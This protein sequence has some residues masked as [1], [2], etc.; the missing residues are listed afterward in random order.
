MYGAPRH[1]VHGLWRNAASWMTKLALQHAMGA[2]AATRVSA[3]RAFRR[4]LCDAFATYNGPYVSIDV[5]LT[6]TTNRFSYVEVTHHER[7]IG[8]SNYNVRRLLRHALTM[9]TGFST[10]PLRIASVSGL[11]AMLFGGLLL[12]YILAVFFMYGRAVPGFAFLASTIAILSGVQL[13]ALGVIG[14]YLARV[15]VR[16]MDRPSYVIAESSR[17]GAA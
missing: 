11:A 3:F 1:G 15:H 14:E 9:I 10:L 12:I 16:L 17:A 7:T 5:L 2:E 13:F 4:K 8:K 6:W